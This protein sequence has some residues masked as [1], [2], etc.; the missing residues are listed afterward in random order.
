MATAESLNQ[1]IAQ[2]TTLFNELRLQNAE[3]SAIEETKKKLGELKKSLGALTKAAGGGKKKERMLLKT[4]KVSPSMCD[5]PQ[6]LKSGRSDHRV[7]GIMALGRCSVVIM[8]SE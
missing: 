4:A 8:S 7:Q 1:E 3:P 6:I 5:L 2:Q